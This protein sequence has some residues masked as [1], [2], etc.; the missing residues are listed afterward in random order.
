MHL[1]YEKLALSVV[2]QMSVKAFAWLYSCDPPVRFTSIDMFLLSLVPTSGSAE[3][4][5]VLKLDTA[6]VFSIMNA[7]L[8]LLVLVLVLFTELF[9]KTVSLVWLCT[10]NFNVLQSS[11]DEAN[12]EMVSVYFHL[13]LDPSLSNK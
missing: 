3:T 7:I 13:I 12:F 2:G 5:M 6:I 1:E 11:F 4:S 9:H 10:F 8:L